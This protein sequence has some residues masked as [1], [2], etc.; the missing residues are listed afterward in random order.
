MPRY[1]RRPNHPTRISVR[2]FENSRKPQAKKTVTL[3]YTTKVF[4]LWETQ[5]KVN[6][7]GPK[8]L[9]RAVAC[10]PKLD[11]RPTSIFLSFERMRVEFLFKTDS[12]YPKDTGLDKPWQLLGIPFAITPIGQLYQSPPWPIPGDLGRGPSHQSHVLDDDDCF[13]YCKK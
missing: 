3:W 7:L 5:R 4:S 11:G 12:G 9:S 2:D 6:H 8:E 10:L 1:S 13:Y